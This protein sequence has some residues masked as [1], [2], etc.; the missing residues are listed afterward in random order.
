[1]TELIP[2]EII[3]EIFKNLSLRELIKNEIVC[4]KFMHIVRTTKW[5]QTV[6]KLKDVNTIEY[7]GK[8]YKFTKYDFSQWYNMTYESVK[9]LGNCHTLNLS[10]CCRITDNSVKLLTNCH[11]LN[12]SECRRITDKSVK[13]LGNCH[14]LNLTGC[15]QITDESVK[16]L[17]K[18]HTLNLYGCSGITDERNYNKQS[19]L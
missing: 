4:K 10:S 2:R 6:V 8:N 7:V 1:M 15:F 18:C 19:L 13:L 5:D 17:G 16:L 9:L 12:L 11:T 3:D 14:T